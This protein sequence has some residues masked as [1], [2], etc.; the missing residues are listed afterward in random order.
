[1]DY[2]KITEQ[3]I[4]K[5]NPPGQPPLPKTAEAIPGR[6]ERLISVRRFFR[7]LFGLKC[8]DQANA[9]DAIGT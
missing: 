1:M 8:R 3:D 2:P 5:D 9:L 4:D 6:V 7:S